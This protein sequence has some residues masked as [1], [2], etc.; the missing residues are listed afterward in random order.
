MQNETREPNC[1][2]CARRKHCFVK[3]FRVL[4][5]E[6]YKPAGEQKEQIDKQN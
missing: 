1:K 6:D 4:S 5:C 3:E 2:T